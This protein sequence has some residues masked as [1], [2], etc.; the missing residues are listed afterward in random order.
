M[1]AANQAKL[2]AAIDTLVKDIWAY[3]AEI[4]EDAMRCNAGAS[5]CTL[6]KPYKL[7]TVPVTAADLATVKSALTE[8]SLPVWARQCNA[9]NPRCEAVWKA[10]V[11]AGL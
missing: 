9:V 11:G 1:S 3:S 8:R 4:Y 10:T 2:Q 5:P 6:G 7:E